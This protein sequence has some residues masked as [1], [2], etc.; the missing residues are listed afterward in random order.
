MVSRE[1]GGKGIYQEKMVVLRLTAKVLEDTLLPELLHVSP[2]IN[3]TMTHWHGDLV[4]L[5]ILVG[6]VTNEEV[7]VI[8]L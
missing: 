6:L 1:R 5:G 4:S 7:K 3:L 2:V 8:N